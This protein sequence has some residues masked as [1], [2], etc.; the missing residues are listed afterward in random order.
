MATKK[1]RGKKAKASKKSA[2]P[3]EPRGPGRPI[4]LTEEVLER[5]AVNVEGGDYLETAAN[6]E[7]V[8]LSSMRLMLRE[9]NKAVREIEDNKDP[10]EGLD[11]VRRARL[12]RCVRFALRIRQAKAKSQHEDLAAIRDDGSWQ[13]RAWRL[14]RKFP[15]L[16]GKRDYTEH[17]HGG[18]K[19][20]A[21]PVRQITLDPEKLKNMT[22]EQLH[23]L[24]L[25]VTA[26]ES[27]SGD[28]SGGAGAP[29]G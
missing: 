8:S 12:E 6:M 22:E 23:V 19:G 27:G 14:E 9:G 28:D 5:I 15:K 17:R 11:D 13:A 21:I 24:N 7:G 1:K 10:S 26:Y 18:L 2:A 16:F 29:G 25:A 3:V 20:D 4:E